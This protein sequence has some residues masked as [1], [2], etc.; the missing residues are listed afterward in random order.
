MRMRALNACLA[1]NMQSELH[2]DTAT[3]SVFQT[4]KA[5]VVTI[6]ITGRFPKERCFIF[7]VFCSRFFLLERYTASLDVQ[8]GRHI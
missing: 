4:S 6:E 2:G 5:L 1:L 3:D 8:T 7:A